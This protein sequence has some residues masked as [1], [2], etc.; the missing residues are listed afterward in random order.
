[1]KATFDALSK[2][3]YSALTIKRIDEEFL[4]SEALI[5]HHYESKD[6]LLLDLL[7]YLLDRFEER[8]IPTTADADPEAELRLIFD[9][10]CSPAANMETADFENVI[11]ELQAQAI[12]DE[13]YRAYFTENRENFHEHLCDIIRQGVESGVFRDVDADQVA[14]YL[15]TIVSGVMFDRVTTDHGS[16][17][18]AE[19]D[20]YIESRLLADTAT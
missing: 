14:N 15:L 12:Q 11:I 17:I 19:I 1:M 13:E 2:H 6:E 18:R 16:S 10:V 3:G 20:H 8:E 5:F 9:N 7:R 4:K